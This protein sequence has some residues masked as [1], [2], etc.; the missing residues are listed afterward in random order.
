MACESHLRLL[1]HDSNK[2]VESYMI[3][4]NPSAGTPLGAVIVNQDG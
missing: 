4:I 3:H 2:T 1:P